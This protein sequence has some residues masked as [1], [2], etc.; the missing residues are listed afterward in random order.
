MVRWFDCPVYPDGDPL[1]VNI[2]QGMR[3]DPVK[4]STLLMYIFRFLD[5]IDPVH[6]FTFFVI[7]M[8][9]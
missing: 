9:V 8:I 4:E 7:I 5:G 2:S 6:L 1:T 3:G